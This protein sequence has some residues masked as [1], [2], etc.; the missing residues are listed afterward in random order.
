M[1][2]NFQGSQMYYAITGKGTPLVLLHG[3]LEDSRI[4]TPFLPELE[5]KYQVVQIDLFGHGNSEAV[6]EEHSMEAMAEMVCQVLT[7]NEISSAHFIGHSL[8]GYV[9]LAFAEKQPEKTKSL[10]L[11]NST[12]EADFDERKA[13]RDRSVKLLRAHKNSF[14]KMAIKNLFTPESAERHKSAIGTLVRRAQD[15]PARS[16]IPTVKGM[17]NRRDRTG[18]LKNYKGEKLIIAGKKDPIMP[19]CDVKAMARETGSALK[20]F[21]DGHMSYL[22]NESE[23][24]SLLQAII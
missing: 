12:P 1:T 3:F 13:H 11:L 4:W 22:E 17:K 24:K 21:P 19:F 5:R 14:V 9:S 20:S 10:V 18:V 23:F 7:E 16:V 15:L 2:T 6:G 8:G